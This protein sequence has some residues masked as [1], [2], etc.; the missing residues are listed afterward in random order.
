MPPRLAGMRIVL[1]PH[2]ASDVDAL[3][4]LFSDPQVTRHWS[5]PSWTRPAQALDYLDLRRSLVPP[6]VYCWVIADAA[7]AL[8]GT[9]TL[10]VLHGE[11]RRG[12][13][14]YALSPAQQG[15]GLAGEA[16][17]LALEHAFTTLDLERIEADVDPRNEPSWRLLERIGFRR[18]ALLHDRC[19]SGNEVGDAAIYGLARVDWRGLTTP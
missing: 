17:R 14:G 16:L 8:I 9:L 11:P 5:F 15:R 7:D 13:L 10:F 19:R 6:A 18:E 12:E 2:R 1:R 4:A 3:Y